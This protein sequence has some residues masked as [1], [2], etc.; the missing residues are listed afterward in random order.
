MFGVSLPELIV[1]GVVFL[2][3][4]GPEKLPDTARRIGQTL[5]KIKRSSDSI[6]REFYNTIY[7]PAAELRG[8][9]KREIRSVT[10]LA[11]TPVETATASPTE[12]SVAL[13]TPTSSNKSSSGEK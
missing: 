10:S 7:T 3:V 2:L 6:R 11:T 1:I 12:P 13:S 8:E 5:G 9:I 4:V